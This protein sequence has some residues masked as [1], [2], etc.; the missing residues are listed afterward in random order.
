MLSQDDRIAC[1]A[2]LPGSRDEGLKLVQAGERVQI[3]KK[4][5]EK[6]AYCNSAPKW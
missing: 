4:D 6:G 1:C 3:I 2:K 5:A